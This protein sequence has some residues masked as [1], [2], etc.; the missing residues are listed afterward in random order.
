MFERQ[1]SASPDL[2]VISCSQICALSF[3]SYSICLLITLSNFPLVG[4][5]AYI[6]D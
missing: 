5:I 3:S 1:K 6:L 2:L 4:N